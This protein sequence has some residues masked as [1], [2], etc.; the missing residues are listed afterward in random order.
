MKSDTSK[1]IY[2]EIK[3]AINNA[4]LLFFGALG[5]CHPTAYLFKTHLMTA[6]IAIFYPRVPMEREEK[7]AHLV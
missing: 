1:L 7:K 2:S 6:M 3:V 4:T 5:V